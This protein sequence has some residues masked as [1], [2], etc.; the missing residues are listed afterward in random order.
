MS[1]SERSNSTTYCKSWSEMKVHELRYYPTGRCCCRTK[2]VQLILCRANKVCWRRRSS[3]ER[4]GSKSCPSSTLWEMPLNSCHNCTSMSNNTLLMFSRMTLAHT[5]R[6]VWRRVSWAWHCKRSTRR[7]QFME[8]TSR[9]SSR[10]SKST[11]CCS[12]ATS[13]TSRQLQW[14]Y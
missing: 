4:R 6:R 11:R 7:A 14:E 1:N 3:A 12:C 10:S 9:I 8:D 13:T 2:I 5:S